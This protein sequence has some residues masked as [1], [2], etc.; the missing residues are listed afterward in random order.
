MQ[1]VRSVKMSMV[2][3]WLAALLI[4]WGSASAVWAGNR[5][6]LAEELT[7]S[8]KTAAQPNVVAGGTVAYTVSINNTG[9][10]PTIVTITDTLPVELTLLSVS[11]SAGTVNHEGNTM[12][13][14]LA[15]NANQIVTVSYT[16][17]V[18]D[19]V[20]IGA[21]IT[22][23]VEIV[24][25]T[26]A[27]TRTATVTVVEPSTDATVYLPLIMTAPATP[28]ITEI[29][30]L[31][32]SSTRP[33]SGNSRT[34]SWTGGIAGL[35]YELQ[36]A[37][38][39]D[40]AAVAVIGAGSNT[41]HMRQLPASTHNVHF[42]RVRGVHNGNTG[43]WSNVVRVV[44]AYADDFSDSA[45]GWA[46]ARTTFIEKVSTYYENAQN[47]YPDRSLLVIKSEDSWDWGISSPL[48]P[49][50]EPP[51]VIE[52]RM[53][54]ANLGNLVSA[55]PVFGS[56]WNGVPRPAGCINW[57]TTQ[58][59][60][61]HQDCFNHFYFINTIWYGSVAMQTLFE[62][63]DTLIWCPECGGSPMKRMGDINPDTD[64]KELTNVNPDDFNVYR[65]EVRANEIRFYANGAYQY[66][67]ND[68]R[69]IH[70]PYFG[71]AATT[72]EYSNSTWVFDYFIVAP[73]DE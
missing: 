29:P 27:V 43:E 34:L 57:S 23:T 33:N 35:T 38:T 67:Y 13:G 54:V 6:P 7:S 58:T 37:Q 61:A 19:T 15:V 18:T 48:K 32:L 9:T 26:T 49:A 5:A 56:D 60:Y 24:G 51:Y 72:D 73:L 30:T 22:N 12:T 65:I 20:M 31:V 3:L 45:S 16:A 50:P 17:Q 40:F 68:T 39:A 1:L 62:R 64:A 69:Y 11:A 14:T 41:S 66:S 42:Y 10:S 63:V 4:G 36:E 8:T 47:G 2:A 52:Y 71:V 46:L 70:S 21:L 25:S 53:R 28:P 44:G 55:G 59:V